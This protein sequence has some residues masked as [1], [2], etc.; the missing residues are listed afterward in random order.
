MTVPVDPQWFSNDVAVIAA[1]VSVI[2]L[3]I[4]GISALSSRKQA[5]AAEAQA[6][7][8]RRA[9]ETN[10][11]ALDL[12]AKALEAQATALS[13]QAADTGKALEIAARSAD[14]AERGAAAMNLLAQPGQRPWVTLEAVQIVDR[15]SR[16]GL[17]G[18]VVTNLR[19]GGRTP[20]LDLHAA[21]WTLIG[22]N[23]PNPPAY[24]N[25]GVINHGNMGPGSTGALPSDVSYPAD[26]RLAQL[27]F[28]GKMAV[29]VYG[30][31]RYRDIFGAGHETKWAF[32]FRRETHQFS[33]C[34]HHNEVT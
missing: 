12:Q 9:R 25:E 1:A 2:A 20:A 4:S 8:A 30:F 27:L 11:R 24:P 26:V 3:V 5:R 10:E 13:A 29:F 23:L 32:Q 17:P 15:S 7:E 14:A 16:A 28:E 18:R 6:N 21:Q 22:E 19:N 34:S 33:H 31:A